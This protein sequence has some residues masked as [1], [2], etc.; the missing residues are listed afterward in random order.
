MNAL[1]Q[2]FTAWKKIA[3]TNS[4]EREA[5]ATSINSLRVKKI[6]KVKA[7]IRAPDN[8]NEDSLSEE[9]G[10][11]ESCTSEDNSSSEIEAIKSVEKPHRKRWNRDSVPPSRSCSESDDSS[12]EVDDSSS[13]THG[14]TVQPSTK[15]FPR[16]N[17][18]IFN[19][20][21]SKAEPI[22]PQKLLKNPNNNKRQFNSTDTN[23]RSSSLW[24]PNLP[25]SSERRADC[26]TST[27]SHRR[28][29]TYENSS[30]ELPSESVNGKA[31]TAQSNVSRLFKA[32][33]STDGVEMKRRKLVAQWKATYTK[34]DTVLPETKFSNTIEN[35]TSSHT[36]PSAELN[37]TK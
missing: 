12:S 20:A 37:S 18:G 7:R 36:G 24:L 34:H 33:A 35:Q 28:E 2:Q 9:E 15:S 31:A 26:M 21:K 25:P 22:S 17:L 8:P 19:R 23:F 1:R 10:E 5:S 16:T 29:E 6:G 11:G 14:S 3:T 27:N 30:N 13:D 32:F 4:R